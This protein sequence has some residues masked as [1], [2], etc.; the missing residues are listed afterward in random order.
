MPYFILHFILFL[1]LVEINVILMTYNSERCALM[2]SHQTLL[3]I[4][5]SQLIQRKIS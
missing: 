1:H 5:L 2:D 3:T 4:S